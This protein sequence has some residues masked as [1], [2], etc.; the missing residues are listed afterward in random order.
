MKIWKFIRNITFSPVSFLEIKPWSSGQ[1]LRKKRYRS[2][3][4]L[5]IFA[6]F[7]YFALYILSRLWFL[8]QYS[9]HH[10]IGFSDN[11]TVLHHFIYPGNTIVPLLY[12]QIRLL[13]IHQSWMW[14]FPTILSFHPCNYKN[15]HH[16]RSNKQQFTRASKSNM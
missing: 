1:K 4:V 15:Y 6:W 10:L 9:E 12:H 2:L 5:F 14:N 16:T 7:F 8:Y 11:S 13:E 3:I